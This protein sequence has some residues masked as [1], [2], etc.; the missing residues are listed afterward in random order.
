MS[1][2]HLNHIHPTSLWIEEGKKQDQDKHLGTLHLI[3]SKESAKPTLPLCRKGK[4]AK[5]TRQVS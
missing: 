3:W 2:I 1:K 4:S 5:P